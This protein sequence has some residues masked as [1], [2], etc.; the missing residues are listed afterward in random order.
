M[1]DRAVVIAGVEGAHGREQLG[2]GDPRILGA[3]LFEQ[4]QRGG[5]VAPNV[6]DQP[7]V[8]ALLGTRC[9]QAGAGQDRGWIEA[10]ER[11]WRPLSGDPRYRL[12]GR[13]SSTARPRPA[14]PA[15]L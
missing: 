6:G 8:V 13:A 15:R 7:V 11:G 14:G 4:G 5:L 9:E 3:G 10:R 12:A 2:T 1:M